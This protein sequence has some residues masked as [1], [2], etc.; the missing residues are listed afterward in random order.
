[1]A[2]VIKLPIL[3][4]SIQYK[5]TNAGNFEGFPLVIHPGRLT[6]NIQITHLE[7]KMIFQTSMIMFHVNLPGCSALLEYSD[8]QFIATLYRRVGKTP[9]KVVNSKG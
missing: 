4:V 3:E 8:R 6:W 5:Y 9:Q 7:R 2:G 1:M